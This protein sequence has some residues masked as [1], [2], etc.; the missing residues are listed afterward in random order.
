VL[1]IFQMAAGQLALRV[2]AY[3][4][5]FFFAE[6]T[7]FC[8]GFFVHCKFTKSFSKANNI[9]KA[10][11]YLHKKCISELICYFRLLLRNLRTFCEDNPCI[12][13]IDSLLWL[14][15]S[16][17]STGRELSKNHAVWLEDWFLYVQCFKIF[18]SWKS[19]LFSN[20]VER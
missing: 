8:W 2:F 4:G 9:R 13:H 11:K 3:A 18:N 12:E 17:H 19:T 6:H 20:R 1:S 14:W 16:H 7:S 5:A 10:L 15:Q